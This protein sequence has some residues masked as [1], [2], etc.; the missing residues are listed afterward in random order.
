MIKLHS[1]KGEE[2]IAPVA[3][4]A[5]IR[6]TVRHPHERFNGRGYPDGLNNGKIPL[7]A[8]IIA[9]A[10]NYQRTPLPSGA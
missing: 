1:V 6:P 3:F 8:R 10:D 7:L 4:L 5:P 9:V 2:I